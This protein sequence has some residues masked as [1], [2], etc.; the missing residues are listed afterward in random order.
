MYFFHY[1]RKIHQMTS[2]ESLINLSLMI[3]N[4]YK[5]LRWSEVR[6]W[7]DQFN[8]NKISRSGQYN[9]KNYQ[10]SQKNTNKRPEKTN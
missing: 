5:F 9:P 8:G 10:I 7:K 4:F 1:L 2:L 6:L 3:I